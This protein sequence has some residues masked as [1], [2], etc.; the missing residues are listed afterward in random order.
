MNFTAYVLSL[1]LAIATQEPTSPWIDTYPATAQ[2]IARRA[3]SAPLPGGP[4]EWSASV[5]V[6]MGW[7]ES[8]FNAARIG[9]QGS[10]KGVWQVHAA[11]L[12][13]P[14]PDDVDGQAQGALEL[15]VQSFTICRSRPLGERLGWYA[16]GGEGC[17]R[18]L[19]L[20]RSRLHEAAQ[21]LRAHPFPV[22]V[23][24]TD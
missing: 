18:R 12:G 10:A 1:M 17:S 15:L 2:A 5:F 19:G 23:A 3:E 8:R 22:E 20:S 14:V 6:V 11:T 21:L 24:S 16:A 9:D 4:R 7:H 13:R